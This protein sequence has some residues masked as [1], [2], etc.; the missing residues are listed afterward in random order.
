MWSADGKSLFYV[1]DRSGAQNIWTMPIGGARAAGHAVHRRPRAVADDLVRRPHDRLR[2]RLR[3]LEA[4]HRR[5]AR[6][7]KVPIA[8][9]GAAVGA[10]D[11]APDA[12]QRF[13]DLAL[14]PDGRKVV[15]RRARRDLGGVRAR[16]RRRRARDAHAT[17]AKSQIE[18]APD[19]RRIVY[20]SERDGVAAPLPL[21]LHH[22]HA[23]RS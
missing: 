15:V 1:S 20:V 2:A 8:R 9:R 3:D 17:R 16:R 4:G 14:S 21:R 19:S 5:A 7:R 22:Q 18:W 10:G 12:E 6:P 11:R 13:Q 23:R